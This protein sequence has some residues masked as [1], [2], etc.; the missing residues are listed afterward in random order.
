MRFH[1]EF[2][3]KIIANVS[4]GRVL[5]LVHLPHSACSKA[6]FPG[7]GQAVTAAFYLKNRPWT[8]ITLCYANCIHRLR[9]FCVL[10]C[11]LGFPLNNYPVFCGNSLLLL[12]LFFSSRPDGIR[13]R[14]LTL[15]ILPRWNILDI[16]QVLHVLQVLHLLHILFNHCTRP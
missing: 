11:G 1:G 2:N 4:R 8:S 5:L 13:S 9:V 12:S 10:G 16:F 15:I 7:A 3:S 6:T 14:L